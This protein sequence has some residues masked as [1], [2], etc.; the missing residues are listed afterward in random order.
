VGIESVSA[1]CWL[2]AQGTGAV[3]AVAQGRPHFSLRT[4]LVVMTLVAAALGL[5]VALVHQ[6][7]APNANGYLGAERHATAGR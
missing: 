5:I 3:R 6:S 7:Y 4:Q 2:L 1:S